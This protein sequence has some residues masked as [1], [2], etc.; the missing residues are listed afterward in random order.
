MKKLLLTLMI[1][2]GSLSL[3]MVDAEARRMGGGG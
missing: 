2:V 3:V 1:A